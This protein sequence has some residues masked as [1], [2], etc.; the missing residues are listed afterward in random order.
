M[1][2]LYK[3]T[4][5]DSRHKGYPSFSYSLDFKIPRFS[6]ESYQTNIVNFNQARNW[7]S[8]QYG[9]GVEINHH[10]IMCAHCYIPLWAWDTDNYKIK[11]YLSEKELLMFQLRWA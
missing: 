4:K 9:P 5:L 7:L 1:D 10:G 2:N 6:A 11:F 8:E 3:L